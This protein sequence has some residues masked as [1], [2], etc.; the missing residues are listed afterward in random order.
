MAQRIEVKKV[1]LA[2]PVLHSPQQFQ[3]QGPVAYSCDLI[4]DPEKDAD[5][6]KAI[7]AAILAAAGELWNEKAKAIVTKLTKEGKVCFK[8]EAKTN[9]TGD[10]YAGF[11][12]MYHI[13][14]RNGGGDNR[15]PTKPTLVDRDGT[16]LLPSSGKPYGGCYVLAKL[17]IWAQDNS[18]GQRVNCSL[19]GIQFLKDGAS[20]S[21][22]SSASANEF[23]AYE[24]EEEEEFFA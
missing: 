20:F 21:G 8:R 14:C 7:D 15:A 19:R 11:E 6:V 16:E 10:A 17:E 4:L 22:T 18:F 9:K 2:F 12:G 24:D 23:T 1:R 13:T 3:G 5:A